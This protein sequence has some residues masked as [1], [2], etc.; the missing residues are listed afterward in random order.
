MDNLHKQRISQ[1]EMDFMKEMVNKYNKYRISVI[2]KKDILAAYH[3]T[4]NTSNRTNAAIIQMFYTT[5]REIAPEKVYNRTVHIAPEEIAFMRK[6][7]DA[8]GEEN[9]NRVKSDEIVMKFKINFPDTK[10]SLAAIYA[11]L[12]RLPIYEK[13]LKEKSEKKQINK[14]TLNEGLRKELV[15]L[16]ELIESIMDD[17]IDATGRV[18]EVIG[19][20]LKEQQSNK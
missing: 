3:S 8:V 7:V 1:K 11:M 9:L 16:K 4:F 20:A 6:C 12:K 2:E 18:I 14:S 13:M 17:F 19:L 15:D 5:K 10:R